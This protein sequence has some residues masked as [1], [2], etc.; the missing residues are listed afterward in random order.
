MNNTAKLAKIDELLSALPTFRCKEGCFDCCGPVIISRLEYM[1]CIQASGRTAK[2]I[3]RQMQNNLKQGV[4][5][6][7]L[8]DA[9][10]KRCSVYAVRPAICRLFGVVRGE[11]VCPHGYGPDSSALLEDSQSRE[12][13]GVG[14]ITPFPISREG[15]HSRRPIL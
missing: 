2:D 6:C 14:E 10:T 13:G 3:K 8:L 5:T 4:Y 12:S 11:L 7:P 15:L 9:E 1:R